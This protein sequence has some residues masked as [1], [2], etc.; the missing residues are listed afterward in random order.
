M[1]LDDGLVATSQLAFPD[2]VTNTVYDSELYRDRGRND[3]VPR[4]ADDGI[5]AD[6]TAGELL[7]VTGSVLAGYRGAISVGIRAA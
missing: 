3:S 6:G 1:F 2:D 4:T 7:A 5:F